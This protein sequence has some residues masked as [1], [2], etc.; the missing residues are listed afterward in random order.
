MTNAFIRTQIR[1]AIQTQ[2][3]IRQMFERGAALKA[4]FG[5]ENVFDFSLGNPDVPA[6]AAVGQALH[7]IADQ[8]HT[9]VFFGY[10]PNAGRP[11]VRAGLAKLV[12]REQECDVQPGHV[13]ITNGAAGAI[14]AFFRA[15]I[16]PG[17]EVVCPA[18]Y[19]VEYGF[20]A[21]NYGGL[22]RPVPCT[23]ETFQLDVPAIEAAI[24]PRTRAVLVNSPNNPTGAVYPEADLHALAA[25]LTRKSDELG[26]P[27]YLLADEP[28]RFLAY[29]NTPV[30]PLLPQYPYAVVAS[31][32]SKSLSLAGERLGYLAVNPAMPGA[33]QL[34]QAVTLTNRILGFVNAP[35]IGQH[36]LARVLDAAVDVSV[37]DRR[38]HAM[39]DM[40]D[41]AG[42]DYV[43]PQGAFYFFPRVPAG[44]TDMEFAAHLLERNVIVVPGRGFGCEGYVRMTYC[45]DQRIIERA[46]EPFAAAV[47]DIA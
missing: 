46:A 26:H 24:G 41:R 21:A 37:Y 27:V 23:A 9:P 36:L 4:R 3:W 44:R 25:A 43:M 20:Y 8:A 14:N 12:A 38:R 16:D 42:L 15:V 10:M 45:I 30:P 29:D 7:E 35:V 22:L 5:A 19:F 34:V 47:R 18:P 33:D 1:D 13:I 2:S 31:S 28:Y 17:D 40:L 32:F 11:D 6:P 39:A